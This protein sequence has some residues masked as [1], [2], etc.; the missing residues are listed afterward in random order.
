MNGD[1]NTSIAPVRYTNAAIALSETD[2]ARRSEN[3]SRLRLL[4]IK[5]Y[6]EFGDLFLCNDSGGINLA[7]SYV[8]FAQLCKIVGL[9]NQ[10]IFMRGLQPATVASILEQYTDALLSTPTEVKMTVRRSSKDGL[11]GSVLTYYSMKRISTRNV[12]TSVPTERWLFWLSQFESYGWEHVRPLL[13]QDDYLV[14]AMYDPKT[15][16][17][18]GDDYCCLGFIIA[19]SEAGMS[20]PRS[21]AIVYFPVSKQ[22]LPVNESTVGKQLVQGLAESLD[23]NVGMFGPLSGF[24]SS[25]K[26][27][28]LQPTLT[29][30]ATMTIDDIAAHKLLT[31]G[32]LNNKGAIECIVKLQR[33]NTRMTGLALLLLASRDIDLTSPNKNI[34]YPTAVQ[35][36]LQLGWALWK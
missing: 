2:T 27:S 16:I 15:V 29:A 21:S 25:A 18:V 10:V 11:L 3:D 12:A 28:M 31:T 19:N 30:H 4:G 6:D 24:R 36:I 14:A 1:W 5:Y 23:G 22:W 8:S 34:D 35:S 20:P 26:S 7:L 32:G 13:L 33:G 9:G 17:K